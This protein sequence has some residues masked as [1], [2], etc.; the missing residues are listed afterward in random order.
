MTRLAAFVRRHWHKLVVA[1]LWL[2]AI[3]AAQ[4]YAAAQGLGPIELFGQLREALLG[5]AIAPLL[6][7]IVYLLRPLVLFPASWLTIA[8]GALFGLWG[9][10][11]LA[12]LAGTLS[13]A[14]PYAM[15][16]WFAGDSESDPAAAAGTP[17]RL[18]RFT[19]LLRR[20][21]FQ[22]V[23]TMRLLYLPYDGVSLLAGSLRIPFAAFASATA[24]GN[25]PGAFAY[26]GVG[27][28]LEGD[29][30]AGDLSINPAVLLTSGVV[31][32]LSL[33][34]SYW[35]RRRSVDAETQSADPITESA[36]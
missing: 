9:G 29:L 5:L 8:A 12:L 25:I 21:P 18:R 36:A 3:L 31:L 24:L 14:L 15:G 20:A 26:V 34:F 10:F 27:A 7:V 19:D 28:S 35:L 6:Y 30:T 32:V 17:S 11:A 23:L 22:S 13:A 4:Q 1:L 2:G 16:R 33:A